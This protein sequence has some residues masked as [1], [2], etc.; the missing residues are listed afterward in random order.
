MN[1]E[2][3]AEKLL[4]KTIM[5]LMETAGQDG[6]ITEEEKEVIESIEFSLRFFKQMVVDALEDGV[7][8]T[9]EKYLLEGMKDRIIKEGF[10]IAESINGVSKD[11]MNLLISVMLSLKLPSVSIKI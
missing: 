6:I 2:L 1:R 10:N 4:A 8:T 3:Q 9:N 5:H 7:I 11:E